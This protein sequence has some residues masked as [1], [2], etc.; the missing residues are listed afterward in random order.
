MMRAS[1]RSCSRSLAMS[2]I[3]SVD[4]TTL[5]DSP[6]GG[7]LTGEGCGVAYSLAEQCAPHGILWIGCYSKIAL[8]QEVLATRVP[9]RKTIVMRALAMILVAAGILFG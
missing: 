1:S 7:T 3:S 9:A 4:T 6:G 8:P 2:G 5:M